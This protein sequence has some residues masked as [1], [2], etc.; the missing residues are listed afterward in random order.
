[1]KIKNPNKENI[2]KITIKFEKFNILK[3]ISSK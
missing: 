2:I 3:S 1:M